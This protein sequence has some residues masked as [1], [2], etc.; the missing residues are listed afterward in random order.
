M[1]TFVHWRR[2]ANDLG[3]RAEGHHE[4]VSVGIDR[5]DEVTC[6]TCRIA[7]INPDPTKFYEW[8]VKVRVNATWVADGFEL[9]ANRLHEMIARN[10]GYAHYNEI[11]TE[12]VSAPDA[13]EVAREMGYKS[14]ADR[15]EKKR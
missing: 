12:V 8:T 4:D 2:A 9:N 1:D 6:P 7:V 10:L 13:D 14:A 3:C 11:E 5:K 15:M